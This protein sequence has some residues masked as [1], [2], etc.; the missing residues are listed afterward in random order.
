VQGET[1]GS[2]VQKVGVGRG[3]GKGMQWRE[4]KRVEGHGSECEREEGGGWVRKRGVRD[5]E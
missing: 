4:E 1:G 3:E 5:S 2:V